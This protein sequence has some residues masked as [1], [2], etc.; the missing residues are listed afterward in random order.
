MTTWR[1]KGH[2]GDELEE[3]IIFTNEY[4]KNNNLGRVD[5]VNIPIK[6][7]NRNKNGMITKAFF[8]KKSTVDFHGVIQGMPIVFD[9]KETKLKSLP[10]QNVHFHQI[11]Y[12][13]DI[14]YQG[15]LAFLIIHFKCF[16]EYYL[17]PFELVWKYYQG[18]KNG[19]RKSIPYKAM[20]KKFKIKKETNSILNY[21]PTL[22][23]YIE[24]KEKN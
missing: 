15:G 11:E 8:E 3:L 20:D 18:S 12:M 21:L 23:Y 9:T 14:D 1:S 17:V 4:Y 19:K 16:N 6:V 10:I 22:N 7:I 24:W 5:K 13:K 2:K